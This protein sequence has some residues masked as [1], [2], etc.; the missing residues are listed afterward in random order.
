M[1]GVP[2]PHAGLRLVGL[3]RRGGPGVA[4]ALRGLGSARRLPGRR[5]DRRL[6]AVHPRG[7]CA[8]VAAQRRRPRRAGGL[9]DH[10]P[11]PRHARAR[12]APGD[13]GHQRRVPARGDRT[14]V[15][16]D[17]VAPARSRRHRP[18]AVGHARRRRPRRRVRPVGPGERRQRLVAG[19][20]A[21][22]HR[23]RGPS[24]RARGL[25]DRADHRGDRR[26][27]RPRGATGPRGCEGWG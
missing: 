27:R 15:L 19:C 4:A 8:Q 22:P 12:A 11:R 6:L 7:R 18:V 21:P 2:R 20:D 14:R 26:R 9:H 5:G 16:D 23:R 10:V 3:G 17:A 1:G 13:P 24:E 25:H